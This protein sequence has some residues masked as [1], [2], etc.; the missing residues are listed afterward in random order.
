ME[1]IDNVSFSFIQCLLKTLHKYI[2]EFHNIWPVSS[3][4]YTGVSLIIQTQTGKHITDQEFHQT[5]IKSLVLCTELK[6]AQVS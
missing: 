2:L 1:N 3:I 5:D 4:P 6:E